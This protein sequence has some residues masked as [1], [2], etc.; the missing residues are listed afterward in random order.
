MN[1]PEIW[2]KIKG[3]GEGGALFQIVLILL[4]GITAF[5]LGWLMALPDHIESPYVNILIPSGE[6]IHCP[7]T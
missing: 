6:L 7:K 2:Q 1:I 5:G 4:V 3:V